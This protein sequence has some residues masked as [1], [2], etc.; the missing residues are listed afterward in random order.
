MVGLKE[1]KQ[2]AQGQPGAELREQGGTLGCFLEAVSWDQLFKV[3]R[4]WSANKAEAEEAVSS[5]FEISVLE[6]G[7]GEP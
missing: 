3:E 5:S 1:M 6:P 7:E 2:T 4:G